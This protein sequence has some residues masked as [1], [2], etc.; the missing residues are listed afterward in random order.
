[1]M[2]IRGPEKGTAAFKWNELQQIIHKYY[3]STNYS[4]EA[5]HQYKVLRK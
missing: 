3:E 4:A 1:M 5:Y 2:K